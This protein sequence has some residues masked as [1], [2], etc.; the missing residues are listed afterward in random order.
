MWL[1]HILLIS[2]FILK[3]LLKKLDTHWDPVQVVLF[4]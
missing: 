4:F 2:K 1:E 3:T